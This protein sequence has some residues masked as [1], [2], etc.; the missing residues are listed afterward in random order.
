[1][2]KFVIA[3][4]DVLILSIL[5]GPLS[6]VA[7]GSD[8]GKEQVTTSLE[9]H[10]SM[11]R[12]NKKEGNPKHLKEEDHSALHKVLLS[13]VDQEL[14]PPDENSG[15]LQI[16]STGRRDLEL[17]TH[18]T[19]PGKRRGLQSSLNDT[20][21]T[22][23]EYNN[24]ELLD[25]IEDDPLSHVENFNFG[26]YGEVQLDTVESTVSRDEYISEFEVGM[27]QKRHADF[28]IDSEMRDDGGMMIT[29]L[30]ENTQQ[31][32][33]MEIFPFL[34]DDLAEDS[35]PN[36]RALSRD[37]A[38]RE[39][40]AISLAAWV[41]CTGI[42]VAVGAGGGGPGGAVLVTAKCLGFAINVLSFLD[43]MNFFGGDPT[44]DDAHITIS[45]GEASSAGGNAIAV[46]YWRQG[47][48]DF[49]SLGYVGRNQKKDWREDLDARTLDNVELVL[50]DWDDICISNLGIKVG[51]E[52]SGINEQFTF[53]LSG[54]TMR[55]L[56]ENRPSYNDNGDC[57]WFGD[58][59]S[60]ALGNFEIHWRP[61]R[62]CA[63][64][65]GDYK[66]SDDFAYC[67]RWGMKKYSIRNR[68]GS[69]TTYTYTS[70]SKWNLP[71]FLA[72]PFRRLVNIG[73]GNRVADLHE[74]RAVNRQPVN[75][76]SSRS[77]DEPAQYWD[78]DRSGKIRSRIDP[79]KCLEM[80]TNA[81]LYDKAYV[82][83]CIRD[84]EHQQWIMYTDGRIKHKKSGLYLGVA[85]CGTNSD[86]N[87]QQLELRH[88]EGGQCGEAQ[89]WKF[90]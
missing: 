20:S 33:Q 61:S 62:D 5:L 58:T 57:T 67:M 64:L 76:R 32:K 21:L 30:D 65:Y 90:V 2:M 3:S 41:V 40:F 88:Y 26:M 50:D 87:R 63:R 12:Q 24:E 71:S 19:I 80:G 1:M 35:S 66:Y 43:Q 37:L 73:A 47:E 53:S 77:Y 15:S 72:S 45:A 81:G 89:K 38:T 36:S 78:L 44:R 29:V 14:F 52:P 86:P 13:S 7:T 39:D 31:S 46:R 16:P 55:Y 42:G 70:N 4:V 25:R 82:Y 69:Y 49:D 56:A 51:P 17:I 27:H 84:D 8:T 10:P 34:D 59:A 68:N 48:N 11:L 6:S 54:K 60:N 79:T 22:L 75:L 28:S 83:T 74:R 23:S 85:Y 18:S 9:K